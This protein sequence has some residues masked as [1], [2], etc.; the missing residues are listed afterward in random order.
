VARSTFAVVIAYA[1]YTAGATQWR[2]KYRREMNAQDREANARAI[3]TL[4]NFETVKYFGNEQHELDRDRD[5]NDDGDGDAVAAEIG[6]LREGSPEPP[7]Q[8]HQ[9]GRLPAEQR[10]QP[11]A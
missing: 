9:R 5:E 7:L 3:D 8:R 4:L 10:D 2:M 1:I 11:E 6:H